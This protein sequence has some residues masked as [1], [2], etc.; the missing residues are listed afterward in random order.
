MNTLFRMVHVC[1][2]PLLVCAVLVGIISCRN[3]S[4]GVR[5]SHPLFTKLKARQTGILF[6]ND[7]DFDQAF[8]IYTYRNFYNGGGVGVG[9]FNNDGLLDIYLTSNQQENKLYLNQGNLTFRDITR[10]AGVGGSK[11]WS[12]GVSIAD[13]NGDGWLDIYVCNSGDVE[14]DDKENELFINNGDLTFTESAAAYNLADRGFTTH[15]VF[16]DFDRDQDLDVYLLNNSYQAI[17]S[18]NLMKNERPVRD[19]LG[20][21]KLMRNDGGIFKDVSAAANIY[22]S[23]IGFGLGATVGDVNND[24]WLDIYVSNDFFE[25]DYLYLNQKD[26]TFREVL[27]EQMGSISAASMGADIA[28]INNDGW[29]D[30]FVSEMLPNTN[31]RLKTVTTFD[32]WDRYTYSV[33]NGYHHQFTRNT[34][35]LNNQN[36]GFSE[37]ARL[38]GLEATDWSWGALIFDMDNDGWKDLFVANGIFQDLTNQDYL[39]YISTEEVVRS[40]VANRKVDYK[41]L[42]EL[43]PSNAVPDHAYRNRGDLTF[44]DRSLKWGFQ[45]SNFSN[46][47]AYADFDNDGDLDLVVSHVNAEASF[48]RNDAVQ[49]AGNRVLRFNLRGTGLNP[50]AIGA[51]IRVFDKSQTWTTECIPNKGFQSSVDYRPILGVGSIDTVDRVEVW[52][53]NGQLSVLQKVAT[54]VVTTVLQSEAGDPN[55]QTVLPHIKP[56]LEQVTSTGID[57]RHQENEYVDFD[58]DRLLYS[59]LSNAGPP[60][61]VADVNLDGRDD[62]FVGGAAGFSGQLFLQIQEGR[63]VRSQVNVFSEDSAAEDVEAEF[64]DA[65]SD[66]DPDLYVAS[67][68]NEF[69]NASSNLRDRLYINDG[70]GVFSRSEQ[71]L[72]SLA[73]E[74]TGT[75]RACDFDADGDLDLFVGIRAQALAYGKKM[76]GYLL[77]N[78]GKGIFTEVSKEVAPGLKNLGMITDACWVDVNGDNTTDLVVAGEFMPIRVFLNLDGKFLLSRQPGLDFSNGWWNRILPVDIDRD[79]DMDIVAG[80]LGLNSRFEASATAPLEMYVSDFDK[81]GSIE[82]ILC[83]RE[84]GEVYPWPL[85]HDLLAQLPVLK[86]KY[87][88]YEDYKQATIGELFEPDDLKAA[89]RL[90]VFEAASGI[91]LNS[92]GAFAFQRFPTPAQFSP[93]YAILTHD[94]DSD[95]HID[96]LVGGNQYKVKPEIGRYDAS[97]GTLLR[98]TGKGNFTVMD[99]A[100]SGFS[101]SG[102][103]R[104][105]AFVGVGQRKLL[106]VS[107]NDD[108]LVILQE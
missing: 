65:D 22:G 32:S 2:G 57:F 56:L 91:F 38:A 66:G 41:K 55:M 49:L 99:A 89:E 45:E 85:R 7:L 48:Y 63:F 30:I 34:L 31:S 12:T 13:V 86:K 83:F 95:G 16:F 74:N 73:L 102:E 94:F 52:W 21:D 107:R 78:N 9:D 62:V 104:D 3:K 44:E 87:L 47:S 97:F 84:N 43:I 20:G 46:G 77:V 68:G 98:G 59:M 27:T 15:A 67:G 42:V 35:Q 25:R 106:L 64:F 4:E 40:I 88:K 11:A 29:L 26:G 61:A 80:N 6:R 90:Q 70:K 92:G 17:G 58:R 93:I 18:F 69:T 51:R 76:N 96:I 75:V 8:N 100:Y 37:I 54:G 105:F 36:D 33:R 101:V 1:R 10:G 14:G 108:V 39:Q 24:G 23:V 53:P 82:Q 5:D 79:G 81:N 72:P 28:D 103:I 60:I 71:I 19:S 50:F